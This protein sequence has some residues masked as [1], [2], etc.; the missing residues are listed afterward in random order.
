MKK[1]FKIANYDFKRLMFNPITLIGMV[2]IF[3]ITFVAG[4]I[5][6]PKNTPVYSAT[7]YGV[8]ATQIFN[9]FANGASNKEDTKRNLL[10]HIDQAEEYLEIQ[11][12]VYCLEYDNLVGLS[13]NL[14]NLKVQVDKYAAGLGYTITINQIKSTTTSLK[15]FVEEYSAL[16]E[17]S[18][19]LIFTKTQFQKLQTYAHILSTAAN[20]SSVLE[21]VL[22]NLDAQSDAFEDF[23]LLTTQLTRWTIDA[24][25]VATFRQN[26]IAKAT[27]K[28][29][30]IY[31]A[32]EELASSASHETD[33]KKAAQNVSK[34]RSLITN[35]KFTCENARK[36]VEAELHLLL[37]KHASN[38]SKLYNYTN[39]YTE[40]L[41][42]DL[43]L[44]NYHL[45]QDDLCFKQY[46]TPLNFNQASYK[47]TAFDYTTFALGIVGLL[48]CAFAIFAAYKLFGRDRKAGKMDLLFAQNATF[49]QVYWGKF[50]AILY[51]IFF[52]LSSFAVASLLWGMIRYGFVAQPILLVFNTTKAYTISPIVMLLIKLFSMALQAVFWAVLTIFLMNISRKF[53][54]MFG[55]A[56]GLFVF[57]TLGN[58]FLNTQL[59]YCL[60]PFIHTDITPFLG[61][62]TMKTGFLASSLYT[63]GNFY[64][65][66]IY[67][68]VVIVLLFAFTK[69]L[70]KKN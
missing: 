28:T 32:M 13:T 47:T 54:L 63:H 6:Q 62:A 25:S 8:S 11:D 42:M 22:E 34:M 20:S 46:Q 55:I 43:A 60:L 7:T 68:I 4:L 36:A 37:K 38:Y 12:D 53:E 1:T 24:K 15:N 65:S 9:E 44:I 48:T 19:K 56:I 33:S 64:I 40:D 69:Q 31:E 23:T 5:V 26:Y 17:F 3:A 18:T 70:F 16:P 45:N 39:F 41:K 58:H 66:L 2:V 51:S 21:T 27:A 30:K 52:C 59:W 67:C 61:G 10:K 14:Q 50:L 35:Y 49:S 29:N 57:A